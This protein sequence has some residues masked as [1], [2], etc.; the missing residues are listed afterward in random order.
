MTKIKKSVKDKIKSFLLSK[1]TELLWE[2]ETCAS[3]IRKL[4]ER[5]EVIEKELT[6]INKMIMGLDD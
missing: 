5:Q 3:K 1:R 4:T 6:K 2:E